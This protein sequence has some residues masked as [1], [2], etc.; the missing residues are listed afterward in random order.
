MPLYYLDQNQGGSTP[1]QVTGAQAL[2]MHGAGRG[3]FINH[4]KA[5][6]LGELAPLR[7]NFI[8][9]LSTDSSASISPSEM[10]ANVGITPN[11]SS[12]NEPALRHL[13]QRAQQKIRAIGER[14]EHTFDAKAPLAFGASSWPLSTSER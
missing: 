2:A 13:V 5:F 6:Q 3:R 9:S 10:E 7:Q 11:N 12:P 1:Y 14:L 4:R 8:C